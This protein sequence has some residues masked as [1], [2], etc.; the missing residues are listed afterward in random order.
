MDK[1]ITDTRVL[2]TGGAG[3]IGSHLVDALLAADNQVV[4]LDN[5][6]TGRRENLSSALQNPGFTLI[7][8]D[9]RD[10]QV[11]KKAM[12]NVKIVFHEAALGSVPRSI[13]DPAE[14]TSVNVAGFVNVLHAAVEAKVDSFVYA[15]SSSVYGDEAKLPKQ[16]ERIGT[17]LSPYAVTK[18][19]NELFAANFAAVYGIKVTGLR[20]F[21]VFGP[22]QDPRGAYAAV[23]P[24]FV[25]ALLRNESPV[26]YGDGTNSR[27]FTFVANVV[28]ANLLAACRE[29]REH[30]VYNVAAGGRTDLNELFAFLKEALVQKG[31]PCAGVNVEYAPGRAGDIP[32]S[33]ADISR[34]ERELGYRS[35]YDIKS[36][37]REMVGYYME[38]FS[39]K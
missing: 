1:K 14:S 30:R 27:D 34:A 10:R 26:I 21:N 19:T 37:I 16:E 13:A 9:I 39:G 18:Y 20:Y 4:C 31:V 32:H 22:R 33:F 2:V 5:F 8:G 29:S 25:T 17:A 3:F 15:S 6:A 11:C 24:R 12:E 38:H 36:G 28:S 7:E 23:I 35:L